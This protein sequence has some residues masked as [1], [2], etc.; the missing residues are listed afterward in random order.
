[1]LTNSTKLTRPPTVSLCPAA[2]AYD[3]EYF[4]SRL[5]DVL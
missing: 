1:M 3:Y 4:H 2:E 5:A